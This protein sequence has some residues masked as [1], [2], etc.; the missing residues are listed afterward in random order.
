MARLLRL[1]VRAAEP[2]GPDITRLVLTD[3]DGWDL[4]PFRPGAH[5]D[6]TLP[7]G[8]KRTYSLLNP[9]SDKARYVIGVKREA[10]GRG[11]SLYLCDAARPGTEI[12]AGL[13]RGGL[14]LEGGPGSAPLVFVA[15]GIGLTPFLSAGAALLEAGRTDFT[16][17]LLSRG[18]APLAEDLARLVAAGR[19]VHHDTARA[20]RPD[21]A[22][23]IGAPA[24]GRRVYCCGPQGLT[25]AFE[26]LTEGWPEGQVH[27]ERF[28]PPPLVV[29]P[30]ARPYTLVLA[31][32]GRSI[33]VPAGVSMLD[34]LE[35]AGIKLDCVC[36]GGIC[37]ACKVDYLEGT[38]IHR[39]RILSPADR[40][41]KLVACVALSASDRLVVDL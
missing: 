30:D 20:G 27:V 13:P 12:G 14:D 25:D 38:P 15:G 11:G 8:D 40:A 7:S 36:R 19:V 23:L 39:D 1:V 41:R 22:A 32:S 9:P 10:Q 3:P 26:A 33:D 4:P 17:H 2:A 29:D 34:A 21:L 28:V 24:D 5:I 16:L 18:T 37:G 35:A 31:R 6:L